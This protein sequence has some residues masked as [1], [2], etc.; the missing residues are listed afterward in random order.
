MYK[1]NLNIFIFNNNNGQ[2]YP[3]KFIL[4]LRIRIDIERH[5][6]KNSR[7]KFEIN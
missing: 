3:N 1:I 7:I 2:Y 5:K 6:Q 4:F